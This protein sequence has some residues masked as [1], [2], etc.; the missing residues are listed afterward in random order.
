M[1]HEYQF[2]S[3][4][5]AD[6]RAVLT[7]NRPPVNVITI[8]MLEEINRALGELKEDRS[9]KVL[10]VR[11]EGRCFSAGMDVTDH[12]PD[13]VEQM[14]AAF[15]ETIE[16]LLALEIPTVSAVHGATMGGGLELAA[17]TDLTLA[18]AGAK[19][20]QPEIKLGV[21]PP[22]AA[23]YFPQVLGMKRAYD[24]ILTGRT[25]TAEEAYQ[26]GLVNAVF[27]DEE[28]ASRTDETVQTLSGYSR[29][30][31][32]AT[33]RAIRQAVGRPVLDGLASAEWVYLQEVM[34]TEDALEG[35]TS[36]IEKRR[37]KWNDR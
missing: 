19:L 18:A 26:I 3:Y 8:P 15:H 22:L 20:G 7:L 14:L 31:L 36:F 32:I 10:L 1:A 24:L 35:L 34:A 11:G 21:F 12:L 6:G 37:P 5:Q 16:R 27:A 30:V 4:T 23:A 2:I 17:L 28:F 33:K 25:V 9:A 13:K 29:P